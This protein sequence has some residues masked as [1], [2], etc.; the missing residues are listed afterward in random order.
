VPMEIQVIQ[1]LTGTENLLD[2]VAVGDVRR[3]LADLAGAM[4]GG[5]L[6]NELRGRL[7]EK[8]IIKKSVDKDGNVVM[9][10]MMKRLVEAIKQFRAGWR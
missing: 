10:D 6:A 4:Q 7:D 5:A 1:I 9:S 2:D 3:F 8:G